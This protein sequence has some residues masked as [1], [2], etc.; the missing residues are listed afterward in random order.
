MEDPCLPPGKLAGHL[1]SALGAP[2]F[3]LA[4]EWVWVGSSSACVIRRLGLAALFPRQSPLLGLA[5]ETC[6]V[7]WADFQRQIDPVA[8]WSGF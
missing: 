5:T 3:A 1:S 7:G 4:A 8:G 2:G 6:L